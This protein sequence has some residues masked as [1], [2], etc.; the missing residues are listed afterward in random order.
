MTSGLSAQGE[1]QLLMVI[2]CRFTY[3]S[4]GKVML[5]LAYVFPNNH[6]HNGNCS[7]EVLVVLFIEFCNKYPCNIVRGL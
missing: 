6:C 4:V 1:V 7:K 5:Q 2:W 3:R